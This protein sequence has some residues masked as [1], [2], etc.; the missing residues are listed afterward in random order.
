MSPRER[1]EGHRSVEQHGQLGAHRDRVAHAG[2]L[3]QFGEERAQG[4]PVGLHGG[5]DHR[6]GHLLS[7]A[8]VG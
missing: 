6:R 5:H 1:R 8:L 7:G 3:R 4:D 2:A